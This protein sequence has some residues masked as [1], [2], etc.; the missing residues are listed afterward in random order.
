V[1]TTTLPWVPDRQ[2]V[3]WIQFDPQVGE[4][5]EGEHP[6]VV[7]STKAFNEKTSIVIGFPMTHAKRHETNPFAVPY[8]YTASGGK[9]TGYVLINQPKSFDWRKRGAR[10]HPLKTMPADL[11]QDCLGELN[12]II[13]LA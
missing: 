2:D 10:P 8:T 4:E 9:K 11:F 13:Q 5:M 6:M 1:T 7:L 12:S 3:I